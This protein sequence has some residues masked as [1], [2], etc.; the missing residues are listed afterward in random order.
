MNW[1]WAP[2]WVMPLCEPT[3][4]RRDDAIIVSP[5]EHAAWVQIKRWC[6]DT[7]RGCYAESQ[8]AAEHYVRDF[9]RAKATLAQAMHEMAVANEIRTMPKAQGA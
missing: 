1:Y 3:Q 6:A 9:W 8:H 4:M 2:W 7:I 5:S